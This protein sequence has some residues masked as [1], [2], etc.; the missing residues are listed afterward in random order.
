MRYLAY[1][2]HDSEF[3]GKGKRNDTPRA[4]ASSPT[5]AD[6]PA[7]DMATDER[8]RKK[9]SGSKG[10]EDSEIRDF[11]RPKYGPTVVHL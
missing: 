9:G 5:Q 6:R 2:R 8:K 7:N 4:T 1:I 10:G 3:Q 11:E